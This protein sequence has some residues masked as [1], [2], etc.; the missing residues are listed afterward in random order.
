[1]VNFAVLGCG[2]MHARTIKAHPHAGLGAKAASPVDGSRSSGSRK[3]AKRS[4][5]P[6]RRWNH[7]RPRAS[8]GWTAEAA[9]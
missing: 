5:W 6:T 7:S 1:M 9:G 3:G 2:R 4:G 8:C